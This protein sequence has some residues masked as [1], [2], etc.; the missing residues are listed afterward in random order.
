MNNNQQFD[1]KSLVK[2]L[3]VA[4]KELQVNLREQ[5]RYDDLLSRKKTKSLSKDKISRL[6][7]RVELVSAKIADAELT[8]KIIKQQLGFD[9]YPSALKDV[10]PNKS[11]TPMIA[12]NADQ[13]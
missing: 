10:E 12:N 4:E 8:V 9:E 7:K 2:M 3:S 5:K 11:Y 13:G 1:N 6:Q